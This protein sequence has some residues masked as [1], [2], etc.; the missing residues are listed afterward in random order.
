MK[1]GGVI[2]L[3]AVILATWMY[4]IMKIEGSF[5][6]QGV[7]M[8]VFMSAMTFVILA[9]LREIRWRIKNGI[10]VF[11]TL[12]TNQ[13]KLKRHMLFIMQHHSPDET[14]KELNAIFRN[15]PQWELEKWMVFRAWYKHLIDS[16]IR[17]YGTSCIIKKDGTEYSTDTDSLYDPNA[18]V[19]AKFDTDRYLYED[20][21]YFDDDDDCEYKTK[22]G[23][24]KDA[25]KDG[26]ALG[27]GFEIGSDIIGD[28][29]GPDKLSD[30][31]SIEV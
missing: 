12:E 25:A 20:E 16:T 27:T 2:L 15:Y 9:A 23:L 5:S 28:T 24:Y 7:L 13:E 29:A 26:F 17:L 19:W 31:S 22:K 3:A 8:A 18:P 4:V 10:D 21:D 6:L 11:A 1:K 14:L 30:I